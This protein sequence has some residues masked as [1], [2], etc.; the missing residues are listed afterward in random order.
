MKSGHLIVA[1]LENSGLPV[2]KA[3]D[4]VWHNGV[5]YKI[6]HLDLTTKFCRWVSNFLIGT[7]IRV[8]T[9]GFL[10]PKVYP[11]PGI[12]QCSNLS[13]LHFLIYVNDMPIPSHHQINKSQLA[14]DTGQWA[15]SKNID[16]AEEYL[17]K[18]L[19]Q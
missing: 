3:F 11:R 15:V 8:K 1:F 19:L 2:E 10:S 18:D 12:L 9:K 5:R 6:Y 7:V 16:L 13:Q 14:D 4:N 17:Q